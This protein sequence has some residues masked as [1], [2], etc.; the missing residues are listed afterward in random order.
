MLKKLIKQD[1]SRLE[2]AVGIM[3]R[4]AALQHNFST[5]MLYTHSQ[6]YR[7]GSNTAV[8]ICT[9]CFRISLTK[10]LVH[11][12]EIPCLELED[13]K[14][15]K[16]VVDLVAPLVITAQKQEKMIEVLERELDLGLQHGLSGQASLERQIDECTSHLSLF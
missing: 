8:S 4:K 9:I 5:H 13:P 11:T 1:I 14:L 3:S 12:M 16:R 2:A 15:A 6:R 10:S 7:L